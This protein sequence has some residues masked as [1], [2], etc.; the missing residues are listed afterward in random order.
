[1]ALSMPLQHAA[2]CPWLCLQGFLGREAAT[3]SAMALSMPAHTMPDDALG[4][5]GVEELMVALAPLEKADN[6]HKQKHAKV[7]LAAL[8]S[9]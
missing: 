2:Q 9:A 7:G 6:A 3:G 8:M 4:M 5:A 1:M